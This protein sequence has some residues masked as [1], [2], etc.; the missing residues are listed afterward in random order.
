LERLRSELGSAVHARP[1]I[2]IA[3][4]KRADYEHIHGA[5]AEQI[6]ELLTGVSEERLRS[7]GGVMFRD[8]VTEQELPRS[9]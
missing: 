6:I 3:H 2:F 4:E 8:P 7:L 5:I 9:V 1:R